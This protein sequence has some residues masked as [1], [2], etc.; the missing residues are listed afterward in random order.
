SCTSRTA[1][2]RT[3]CSN[4]H[5]DGG[6]SAMGRQALGLTV[7][8]A[9][10]LLSALV[11][12]LGVTLVVFVVTHL[13]ADPVYLLV[14]QRGSPQAI[15]SLRHQLGYDRPLWVQYGGYL[16]SLAHGDLGT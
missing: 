12:V 6:E 5:R 1:W 8:T 3:G 11:A 13:M 16:W 4:G 14:G 9:R 15:N 2:S 7:F 10:R